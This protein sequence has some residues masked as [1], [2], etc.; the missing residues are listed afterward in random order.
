MVAN[1]PLRCLVITP[2]RQVL[3]AEVRQVTVPA[4]DGEIGILAGHAPLLCILG[5]GLLKYH[6]PNDNEQYVFV[7]GGFCHVLHNTVTLLTSGAL[8]QDEITTEQAR[9]A[10]ND[11]ETLPGDTFADINLRSAAIRRAK[12]LVTLTER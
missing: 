9:S 3:D 12:S 8:S 6:D 1:N 10:L 7:D 11:A 2:E 5:V 4:H